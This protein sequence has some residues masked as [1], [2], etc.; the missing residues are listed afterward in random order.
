MN[1]ALLVIHLIITKTLEVKIGGLYRCSS[2]V[3]PATNYSAEEVENLED[4]IW[5]RKM[6]KDMWVKWTFK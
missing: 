5:E 2:N 4:W 1:V 6:S 3:V